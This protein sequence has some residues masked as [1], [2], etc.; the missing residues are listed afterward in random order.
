MPGCDRMPVA[1]QMVSGLDAVV[2]VSMHSEGRYAF[3]ELRT[4]EMASAALQLSGQ[5]RPACCCIPQVV[6]DVNARGFGA[7]RR[8][9]GLWV[10]VDDCTWHVA[11]GCQL[12]GNL[13]CMIDIRR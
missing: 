6:V 7:R 11:P 12:S 9:S 2:N 5:V 8:M 3:V 10:S 1:L 4:P 13:R